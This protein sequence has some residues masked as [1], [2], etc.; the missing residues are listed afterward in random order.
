MFP[1][2]SPFPLWKKISTYPSSLLQRTVKK[3]HRSSKMSHPLSRILTSPTYLISTNLK[4]LLTHLLQ[5]LNTY[6]G[7]IP[8]SSRLQDILRAGG[9]R[10]VIDS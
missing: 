9:M 6:R 10:N 8:S 3:K 7:R 4:M 5:I 1:S 2:Q